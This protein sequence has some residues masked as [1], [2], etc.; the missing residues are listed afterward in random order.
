MKQ[1]KVDSGVGDIS[2]GDAFDANS[3]V[4]GMDITPQQFSSEDEV[5]TSDDEDEELSVG[6]FGVNVILFGDE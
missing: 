2:Y 1:E 4:L 3:V 5:T 6:E